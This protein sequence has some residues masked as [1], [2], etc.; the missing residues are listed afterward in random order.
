MYVCFNANLG[1][2]DL[3]KACGGRFSGFK[4][5]HAAKREDLLQ[6]GISKLKFILNYRYLKVNFLVPEN[7]L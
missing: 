5:C 2:L 3:S 4:V 1:I 6:S 7:L